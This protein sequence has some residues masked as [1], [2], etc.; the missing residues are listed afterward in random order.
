MRSSEMALWDGENDRQ[1]DSPRLSTQSRTNAAHLIGLEPE[2][3][4]LMHAYGS[5]PEWLM[6]PA[7]A[8]LDDLQGALPFR[9]LQ[10]VAR[11]W[12]SISMA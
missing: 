1:P 6:A 9:G 10:I 4:R 8:V 5:S 3:V 2:W 7:S 12:T 11:P